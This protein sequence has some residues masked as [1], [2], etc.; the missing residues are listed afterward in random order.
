VDVNALRKAPGDKGSGATFVCGHPPCAPPIERR[1][2]D[3]LRATAARIGGE[4]RRRSRYPPR[5]LRS[6]PVTREASSC[7]GAVRSRPRICSASR[8]QVA[9]IFSLT[10]RFPSFTLHPPLLEMSVRRVT[11]AHSIRAVTRKETS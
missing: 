4:D 9:L 11:L 10:R 7:L 2:S 8:R 1:S 3:R 6:A 5:P